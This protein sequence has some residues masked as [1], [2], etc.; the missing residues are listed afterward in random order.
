MSPL[1]AQDPSLR[2]KNGF[3]QDDA[4][5][6]ESSKFKLSHTPTIPERVKPFENVTSG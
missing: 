6:E 2:V 4:V 5:E 3:A 1:C